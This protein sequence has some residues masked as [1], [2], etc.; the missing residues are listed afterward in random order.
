MLKTFLND[1]NNFW[2]VI[3]NNCPPNKK[4]FHCLCMWS[5]VMYELIPKEKTHLVI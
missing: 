4:L 2:H 5:F 3:K 1:K